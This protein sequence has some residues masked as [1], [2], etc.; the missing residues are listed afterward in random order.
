[1]T[2][3]LHTE[4]LGNG[5]LVELEVVQESNGLVRFM[6]AAGGSYGQVFQGTIE[7]ART[8]YKRMKQHARVSG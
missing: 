2:K 7:D 5:K 6:I 3:T 8:E 1:M 4:C